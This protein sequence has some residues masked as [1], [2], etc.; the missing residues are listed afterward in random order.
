MGLR[1]PEEVMESMDVRFQIIGEGGHIPGRSFGQDA[2]SDLFTSREMVVPP[3]KFVNLPTGI[4]I[5]IPAGYWALIA[6]RSSASQLMKLMVVHGIIDNGYRGE[7]F[8]QVYN[9]NDRPITV[10]KDQRIGQVILFPLVIPRFIQAS[11]L[12]PGERGEKGFGSTGK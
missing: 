7:L 12:S 6:G 4:A 5:E 11:D 1:R 8:V 2:G 3:H 9:P 10:L